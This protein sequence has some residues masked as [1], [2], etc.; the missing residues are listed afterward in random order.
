MDVQA[1]LKEEEEMEAQD[2]NECSESNS[3][4]STYISRQCSLEKQ[5]VQ[6]TPRFITSLVIKPVTKHLHFFDITVLESYLL[7]T[8]HGTKMTHRDFQFCLPVERCFNLRFWC[9]KWR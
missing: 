6:Q 3:T 2:N 5:R 9:I 4:A 1:G 8:A 7:W